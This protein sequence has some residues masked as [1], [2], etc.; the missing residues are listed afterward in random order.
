MDSNHSPK[1]EI[2]SL[3]A[4]SDLLSNYLV[5]PIQLNGHKGF[6]PLLVQIF[7]R[8]AFS[9]VLLVGLEPTF[10][11]ISLFMLQQVMVPLAGFEPA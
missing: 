7:F 5:A 6:S 9:L 1:D 11:S 10:N 2:Y 8:V 4:E 3:A